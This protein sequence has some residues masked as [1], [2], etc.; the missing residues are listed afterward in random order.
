MKDQEEEDLKRF[1]EIIKSLPEEEQQVMER[2]LNR[3]RGVTIRAM[4]SQVLARNNSHN[5]GPT[6]GGKPERK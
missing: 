4:I 1:E 3:R 6:L 5:L 2:E